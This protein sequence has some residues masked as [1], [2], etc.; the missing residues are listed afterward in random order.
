MPAIQNERKKSAIACWPSEM[1]LAC[2]RVP[3]ERKKSTIAQNDTRLRACPNRKKNQLL[4][5]GHSNGKKEISYCR[6][7]IQND[8][9]P[10]ACPNRKKT[11]C[12]M[13]AIQD[14]TSL[15]ACPNREITM[16]KEATQPNRKRTHRQAGGTA[17]QSRKERTPRALATT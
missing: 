9:R 13:L 6:L 3:N 10:R 11:N 12:F 4:H 14:D 5:A 7:A 15:R 8:T 1:T 17:N 16:T 2:G